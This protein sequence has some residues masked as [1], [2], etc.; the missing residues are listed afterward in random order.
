MKRQQI[1][2]DTLDINRPATEQNYERSVGYDFAPAGNLTTSMPEGTTV[3]WGDQYPAIDLDVPCR[4]VP[5]RTP[6]HFHLYIDQAVDWDAY[7]TLLLALVNC[8]LVQDGFA[9]ASID[10]GFTTLRTE[11]TFV[12]GAGR[13]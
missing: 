7:E 6:G 10:R 12:P 1:Q 3:G 9:A 2:L 13:S 8:G 4:L 5:S 11:G